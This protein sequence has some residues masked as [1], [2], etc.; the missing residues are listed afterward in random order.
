MLARMRGVCWQQPDPQPGFFGRAVGL[1]AVLLM[2]L[3]QQLGWGS[4]CHDAR[5]M[6]LVLSPLLSFVLAAVVALLSWALFPGAMSWCWSKRG[7]LGPVVSS[8]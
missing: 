6:T 3:A 8:I 2:P 1:G 4:G 7:Y 5:C